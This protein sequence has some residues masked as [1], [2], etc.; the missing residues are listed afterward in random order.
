MY[1]LPL[2][3]RDV[4]F[5]TIDVYQEVPIPKKQMP[6]QPFCFGRIYQT[7]QERKTIKT[8]SPQRNVQPVGIPDKG[9]LD[10]YTPLLSLCLYARARSPLVRV[11]TEEGF[12][13]VYPQNPESTKSPMISFEGFLLRLSSFKPMY[14]PCFVLTY[15]VIAVL[16]SIRTV[17]PRSQHRSFRLREG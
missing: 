4:H 1:D 14:P 7:R 17:V 11:F 8:Q 12:L 10:H 2:A 5:Q 9:R 13:C 16:L 6:H 3:R 15:S